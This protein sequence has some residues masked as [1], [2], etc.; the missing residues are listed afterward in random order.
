MCHDWLWWVVS[1]PDTAEARAI[2]M[3][4]VKFG[5]D[6]VSFGVAFS[7]QSAV[8]FN[9]SVYE[10]QLTP[11]A[12]RETH[13]KIHWPFEETWRQWSIAWFLVCSQQGFSE[14][15]IDNFDEVL[16]DGRNLDWSGGLEV[17]PAVQGKCVNA[18]LWN[19]SQCARLAL[20]PL[21]VDYKSVASDRL[22]ARPLRPILRF[23]QRMK[24]P[25]KK[26][27]QVLQCPR[28]IRKQ[29]RT[30]HLHG[31]NVQV[32]M[33]PWL[34]NLEEATLKKLAWIYSQPALAAD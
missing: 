1:N 16:K 17:R 13:S 22:I 24:D 3:A 15:T 7:N 12:R 20:R 2:F 8:M 26:K 34:V 25:S 10:N 6:V 28:N 4:A 21:G 9:W 32:R 29:T 14:T 18:T 23:W 27:H 5:I 33:G 31:C 30:T 11:L 19:I